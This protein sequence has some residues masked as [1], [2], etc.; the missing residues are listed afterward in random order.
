MSQKSLRD[1]SKRYPENIHVVPQS[2]TFECLVPLLQHAS[3]GTSQCVCLLVVFL[4][5]NEQEKEEGRKKRNT[6]ETTQLC[7]VIHSR[8]TSLTTS[9]TQVF[10]KHTSRRLLPS[11][12]LGW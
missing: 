3:R 8:F 1:P 12:R 6:K 2:K 10:S 4:R 9:T 7:S 11:L 5:E